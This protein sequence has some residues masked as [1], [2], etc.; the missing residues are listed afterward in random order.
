MVEPKENCGFEDAL[1]P[2]RKAADLLGLS[3]QT[4]AAWRHVGDTRLPYIKLSGRAV[5][6]RLSDI[7]SFIERHRHASDAALQSRKVE[8]SRGRDRS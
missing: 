4:L 6:Y 8:V 2:P 7:R 3:V 1:L 5:R